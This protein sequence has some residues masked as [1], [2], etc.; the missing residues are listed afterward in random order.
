MS[1]VV[2]R[3]DAHQHFL[4]PSRFSYPWI[5]G[6]FAPMGR[7]WVPSDLVPELEQCSVG[8]TVVVQ[9]CHDPEETRW[10]LQLSTEVPWV[11]G[12]VG[13]VD[14]RSASVAA[15]LRALR[16]GPGGE[17]LVGIRHQVHDERDPR[18]LL[19]DDVLRG[20]AAV[21]EEGLAFDLLIRTR[22][23]AVAS[24]VAHEFPE[25]RFVIDHLAKP[26]LRESDLGTWRDAL[27]TL[28]R[29]PNAM[30]KVS[31]LVTEAPWDRWRDSDFRAVLDAAEGL[32]GRERLLIG[33]DW[34][35]CTLAA[36]YQEV[37]A[38]VEQLTDD[39]SPGER[40]RLWGGTAQRIYRLASQNN[41]SVALEPG[42]ERHVP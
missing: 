42:V 4:D 2:I 5:T 8:G 17:Q 37:L 30:V 38:L 16:E 7:S 31:G 18:W 10:L 39:W 35:V 22:E 1:R 40:Q 12:V 21:V 33:S 24:A 26:P 36:P 32:F 28:A 14:L 6:P 9:A 13:W 34:P 3:I 29:C 19:R 41:P 11:L 27:R 25:G 15:E 23:A 20:I